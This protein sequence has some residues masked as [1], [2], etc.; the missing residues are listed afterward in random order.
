[1]K[2]KTFEGYNFI[3]DLDNTCCECAI[4]YDNC[5]DQFVSEVSQRTGVPA[6]IAKDILKAVDLYSIKIDGFGRHRF[7]KSFQAASLA[8]DVLMDKKPSV[9]DAKKAWKIGNSVF[10]APYQLYPGVFDML[11][12]LKK[13][14]A[15][16]FL[17]TKGDFEVQQYK[18][19]KNKLHKIF[20]SNKIYIDVIKNEA[21]FNKVIDDYKLDKNKT[22]VIGDSLK[23]DIIGAT[24][25]GLRS[26]FISGQANHGWGYED[27][28]GKPTK[29]IE[30][31]T[32]LME[33]IYPMIGVPIPV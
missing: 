2:K 14:G 18:I 15:N 3:F 19:K 9:K 32:D 25:A 27:E 26:I 10:T 20:D 29:T 13:L 17:V 24:K 31:V 16:L 22:I 21:H 7:P 4:Y 6:I 8:I 12:E 23:D 28:D 1:M 5:Y 30:K 33:I 11:K